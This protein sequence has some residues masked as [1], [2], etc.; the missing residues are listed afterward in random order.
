MTAK[1][2]AIDGIVDGAF[3][4]AMTGIAF[5]AV[6]GHRGVAPCAGL[7]AIA[8]ALRPEI[9]TAGLEL[10]SP[11]SILSNPLSIALAATIGFSIWVATTLFWSPIPGAE[12]LGLT[13]LASA[14]A[15]GALVFEAQRASRRRAERF[16]GLFIAMV[17]AAS[18]AL[19]FEGLSGGYLRDILPPEDLSPLRW[20]DFTALGRGVTAMAPLAFPVAVLLRR[21]SGSW[22]V[23][24]SPVFALFVAAANFSIFANVAGLGCGVLA[25][26][27]A[28]RWPRGSVKFWS[29]LIVVSLIALPFAASLIPAEAVVNGE[30]SAAPP[31]WAQR[32]VVWRDTGLT[33][34]ANCMPWGCGADYA[35]ALG[36][37]GET[38][39]IPGWPIALPSMPVHPH[40]LFLQIWLELGLP[41]VI[42][43]ATALIF[44]TITLL[45]AKIDAATAA[46]I[47]GAVAVSFISV[48][49]EASLWQVWRLAVFTLAAFG[50][51][52]SYSINKPKY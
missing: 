38:I 9:W 1:K 40:N 2:F 42:L 19:M 29:A 14:L 37:Q 21:Y 10:L 35:R 49:F 4:I 44:A 7:M 32:L 31:S 30:F 28:I 46:A 52:V 22:L 34:I 18:A 43:F 15:A 3:I 26:W 11:R 5:L 25:F 24:F 17:S 33:A 16:A 23:A 27:A 20:K 36:E 51:A 8:A 48:M 50:G 47:S 41:G 13:V 6:F 12:W 39:E 45:R